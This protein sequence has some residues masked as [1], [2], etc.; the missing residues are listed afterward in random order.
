[1]EIFHMLWNALA[2]LWAIPQLL[3]SVPL[4]GGY[5]QTITTVAALYYGWRWMP[6]RGK[7]FIRPFFANLILHIRNAFGHMLLSGN[8]SGRQ[9]SSRE[10]SKPARRSL[11]SGAL[12]RM[13]WAIFGGTLLWN[14]E[15]PEWM[16]W[17]WSKIMQV[18]I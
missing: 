14:A 15:H 18:S 17:I 6:E 7:Q 16:N 5:L 11:R 2:Y 3:F 12:L 1:M 13:R 10:L 4:I 8:D 9:A